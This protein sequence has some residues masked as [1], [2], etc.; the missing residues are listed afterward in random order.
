M[1]SFWLEIVTYQTIGSFGVFGHFLRVESPVLWHMSGFNDDCGNET[2][3][4]KEE[5]EVD[6]DDGDHMT[7]C[8]GI[9]QYDIEVDVDDVEQEDGYDQAEEIR[10]GPRKGFKLS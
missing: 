4:R 5:E 6:S 2:P 7:K 3:N 9:V 8:S 10:V 1:T